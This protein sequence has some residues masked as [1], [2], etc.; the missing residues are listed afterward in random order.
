VGLLGVIILTFQAAA[1]GAVETIAAARDALEAKDA[2]RT[3]SLLI[4]ARQALPYEDR[5]IDAAHIGQLFYMEGLAPRVFGAVRERDLDK[6]RDAL[7][8]YPTLKWDRELMDE[9]S[10]RAYFEAIR[11][12]VQQREHQHTQVPAERGLLKAYVDGVEHKPLEAVRSGPHLIQVECPDGQ[13][14]G[15]WFDFDRELNW[16]ELCKKPLD[17][18]VASLNERDPMAGLDPSPLKG[19]DPFP[20]TQPGPK[21]KRKIRVEVSQKALF[22][23]AGVASVTAVATYA[24][25]LASR[26]KYD[27]VND[28]DL[29]TKADLEAQ[30]GKTNTLVGVSI[31]SA[32]VGGGLAAAAVLKGK[33]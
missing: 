6:F 25:A 22:I 7:S 21:S 28:V 14:A 5:I 18:T 30:R 1:G 15:Q 17:L 8:I 33:F 26:A 24:A 20:W 12:E 3:Y 19:P 29:R 10:I 32:A 4:Q 13:I 23:G 9:Q 11:A 2:D 27:D 31:G 16:I